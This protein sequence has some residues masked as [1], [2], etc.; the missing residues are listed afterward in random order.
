[1]QQTS[2]LNIT[3]GKQSIG[4]LSIDFREQRQLSDSATGTQTTNAGL[5]QRETAELP[6]GLIEALLLLNLIQQKTHFYYTEAAALTA[7]IKHMAR[8]M[9]A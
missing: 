9:H 1:M 7:N 3:R 2:I 8:Q 4:L 5:S 6:V